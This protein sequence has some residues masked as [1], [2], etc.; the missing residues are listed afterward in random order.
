MATIYDVAR[1]ARVSTYTVSAVLNRSANVSPALTRRV[2]KAVAALDYTIND[3]ARSLQTRRT[4][5]VAMLIPDIG[6]PFYAKVV[7]GAE[8]VLRRAGYALLLGNTYN[9]P[10]EQERYVALFRAKQAD[11][12]LLFV[13]PG[14][15]GHLRRAGR[16]TVFV[17]RQ[18][19]GIDADLV[20]A[21]NVKGA[22]LAVSHLISRGHRRVA[23]VI[24]HRCLSASA[25]RVKGWERALR[26]ARLPVDPCLV[27]EGD[28]TAASGHRVTLELV[29]L[30]QPPT[31]IFASN[32]L[33][34]T[35]TL[36]ALQERGLEVP[37]D[38]EVMSADDSEWLDVFRPRISSV[39]QPSYEMGARAAELLLDRIDR[40]DR[41]AQRIRLE[42]TLRIRD[43]VPAPAARAGARIGKRPARRRSEE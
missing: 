35:G 22:E 13:A 5:T 25:E 7:R 9:D 36:R 34:M 31:A 26:R 30:P 32:F 15:S 3:L 33:M 21:D 43:D 4:R 40:P 27:G 2:M 39:L 42:P 18:P 1:R 29:A 8:D 6:S 11:G 10:A 12:L 28:W 38:V 19:G 41:E 16:P 14:D 20:V 24:G 17:G 37:G 23:L